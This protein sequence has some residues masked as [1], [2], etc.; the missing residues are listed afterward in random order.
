MNNLVSDWMDSNRLRLNLTKTVAMLIGPSQK[1]N[2]KLLTLHLNGNAIATVKSVKY[3]G[4]L[5]DQHLTWE[6]H[7][8]NVL[9]SV[10]GKIVAI[11]RLGNL[12][13]KVTAMLYKVYIFP[14]FDYCDIVW[15]PTSTRLG[16]IL[17]RLHKRAS[18][19]FFTSADNSPPTLTDRYK[20]HMAIQTYKILNNLCPSYLLN[21]INYSINITKKALRNSY[22]I[23][24]P[25]VRTKFAKNSFYFKSANIWNKLDQCLPPV[26]NLYNFKQIYKNTYCIN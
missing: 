25:Y 10:R 26:L 3:L 15:R 12:P 5:I 18:N 23:Y 4:L 6:E 8:N 16:N 9:K 17:D 19:L 13:S 22:R 2:N 21:T 1:I 11:L 24:V 7:A 20:F 14:I